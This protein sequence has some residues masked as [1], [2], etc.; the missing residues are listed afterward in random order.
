MKKTR[1]NKKTHGRCPECG[2]TLIHDE[3]HFKCTQDALP[4]YAEQFQSWGN[5]EGDQ[6]KTKLSQLPFKMYD[7]FSRWLHQD[8]FGNRTQYCCT[9]DPNLEF[10]PM[11]KS[12]TVLPDPAQQ[13]IAEAILKRELTFDEY[14][15]Q[16][17]VP[18][19]DEEGQPQERQ[20]EQLVFP[21]D[22]KPKYKDMIVKTD[23]TPTPIIFDWD[24]L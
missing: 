8:D 9:Y 22:Y 19:L 6:L 21:R 20:I 17:K 7:M 3:G 1:N 11:T 18:I 13:M 4:D 24:D 10:N 15:G 12:E 16:H 14:Y 2:S 23:F 5:L